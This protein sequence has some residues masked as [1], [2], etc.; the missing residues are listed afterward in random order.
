MASSP[1]HH[2]RNNNNARQHHENDPSLTGRL[3]AS[4]TANP[5]RWAFI[6]ITSL[7]FMWG[8]SYGLLD[9]L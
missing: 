5:Y 9:V 4:R 6:L 7:F 3:S 1:T 2:A 8:L